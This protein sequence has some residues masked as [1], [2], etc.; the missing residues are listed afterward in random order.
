MS[1]S[2]SFVVKNKDS[3]DTPIVLIHG[4]GGSI[5]SLKQLHE[6]LA[7][8]VTNPIYSIELPGMGK[9]PMPKDV[10]N[11]FDYASYLYTFISK[12][13]ERPVILVGHSF[14]GKMAISFNLHFSEYI[15]K[16]ILINASGLKPNNSLKKSVGKFVSKN[17][18]DSLKSNEKVKSFAYKY[19]LR[20]RDY[21]NAGKLKESFALIVDEH[22]DTKV[23]AI[24]SPALIVWGKNDTYVP[25]W[26]GYKFKELIH[27]SKLVIVPDAKHDLPI[28]QPKIVGQIIGSWLQDSII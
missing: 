1:T 24:T 13:I 18:P 28:S 21:L 20:E 22:F 8:Q 25:V 2:F 23:S 9:T 16:T 4:W 7:I 11:T 26:M 3:S 27:D 5:Q 12:H 10:M 19:I 15:E 17:I 14:G 6:Q